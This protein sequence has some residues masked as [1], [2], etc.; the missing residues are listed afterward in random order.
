MRLIKWKPYMA[1]AGIAFLILI[2]SGCEQKSINEIKADPGRYAKR[3]VAI[4]GTVVRSVSILGKGV[5]EI[6]D[7]TGK[8]W[9]ECLKGNGAPRK[10]AKI[11][12]IGTIRDGYDFN[13]FKLPDVIG[14][15]L[16]MIEKSHKAR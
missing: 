12:V 1:W 5:Y 9:V 2:T 16:V 14:T 10:G 8:L 13:M 7:G 3:E 4:I 15:G 11:V 6:D